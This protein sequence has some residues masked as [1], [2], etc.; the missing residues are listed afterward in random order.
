MYLVERVELYL[1]Y[2]KYE[3]AVSFN[4]YVLNSDLFVHFLFFF[5]F[6]NQNII[7]IEKSITRSNI[8]KINIYCFNL[9]Y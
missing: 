4:K 3:Q 7:L 1:E 2:Y 8:C 9:L 6:E 5:F